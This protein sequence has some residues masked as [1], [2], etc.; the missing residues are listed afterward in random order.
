MKKHIIL[1]FLT[2]LVFGSA[3]AEEPFTVI[4]DAIADVFYM[5]SF[6]GDYG[7][8]NPAAVGS[9]YLYQGEGDIKSFQSSAFDD[10]LNGRVTFLYADEIIGG[11]LQLRAE[12][13]T[14]ILGD[15]DAWLRLG[16][17]MKVL[18]GNQGQRGQVAAYQNFDDFLSTKIDYLGI[19]LPFWQKNPPST[20]GNNLDPTRDFPYGYI[21]PSE[22]KGFAK[23][24]GT[25]TNDL[26]MPAGSTDRQVMGYLLDL[27]FAPLTISASAGGLFESLSRPFKTP[28]IQGSGTRLSDYDNTYDP[29]LSTKTNFGF[30][31]EGAQIADILTVAAVYKYADTY[32]AKPEA[33][34]TENTIDEAVR[35]HAFGLYANVKPASFLGIS[36]GYSGLVQSWENSKYPATKPSSAGDIDYETHELSEYRRINFPYYN[37]V[38]LR[39]FFTGVEKLSITFNNNLSFARIKG[40][41]QADRADGSF[42]KG[43]AYA[44]QL[45]ED[46]A[47]AE[48]RAEDYL[49]FYNALGLKYEIN[50]A[51]DLDFQ[52]ANQLGFFTLREDGAPVARSITESLGLYTGLSY[53]VIQRD[54]VRGSIRGGIDLKISSYS[55]QDFGS[56]DKPTHKTGYIDFGIPLGIK[57]EF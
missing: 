55:Y 31:A 6:T 2:A 57:V 43:W 10:G 24:A 18:T 37:G 42:A 27:T 15:W 33:V 4:I 52:A 39:A 17:Y 47:F 5:R 19:L 3:F 11:S 51:L 14:G 32:L 48:K 26:F 7:A 1:L 45:N 40:I 21:S 56:K 34:D 46:N 38:D 22:N 20:S 12:N 53:R 30:R 29:V 54:R 49:G 50:N 25:D 35:N 13:D 41:S 8:K 44:G 23:F 28:W 9:P 16:K 36:A